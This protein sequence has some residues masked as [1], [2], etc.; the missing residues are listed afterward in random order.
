[1]AKTRADHYN[2]VR[3]YKATTENTSSEALLEI[4]SNIH[5]ALLTR[6]KDWLSLPCNTDRRVVAAIL[7]NFD[8]W[9]KSKLPCSFKT[10]QI[11]SGHGSFKEFLCRIGREASPIC[12]HRNE[13]DDTAQHTLERCPAWETDRLALRM[14]IGENLSLTAVVRRILES[15]EKLKAFSDFCETVLTRKEQSARI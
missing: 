5:A 13:E 2:E 4:R 1:M 11:L 6:W 14:I 10:S 7:P 12:D 15:K 9:S 8:A 3:R